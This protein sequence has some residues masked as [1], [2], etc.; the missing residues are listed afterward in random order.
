M[1]RTESCSIN[2]I[3][4]VKEPIKPRFLTS[5]SRKILILSIIF[6]G[7]LLGNY[8]DVQIG[9]VLSMLKR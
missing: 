6:L 2:G 8:Y 7:L 3:C 1:M 5:A 4:I 9:D